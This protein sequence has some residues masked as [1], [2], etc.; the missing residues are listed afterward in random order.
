MKLSILSAQKNH[1]EAYDR[2]LD[3]FND[4]TYEDDFY[5]VEVKIK[6]GAPI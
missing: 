1:I 3:L 5:D 2:L 6:H 4:E